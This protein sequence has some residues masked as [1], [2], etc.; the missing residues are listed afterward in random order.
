MKIRILGC[1]G[2]I[3]MPQMHTTALL[4]DDDVLI[5]AGTGVCRL[6]IEELA[7]VDHVFLTHSH[8][9]HIAALAFL[10]DTV[11]DI[12]QAP[13][14]VHATQATADILRNHIFNWEVWP[15]MANIPQVEQPF[16]QFSPIQV[17][18]PVALDGRKITPLPVNHTVPAVGYHLNSGFGSLVFSGDTGPCSEF[19]HK[20]NAIDNLRYL[21]LECAF[22]NSEKRLAEASLHM[23]PSMLGE[24]LAY[25]QHDV[26]L[27]ITHLK[28][29]Q[30]DITMRE[31]LAICD[32]WRPTMLQEDQVFEL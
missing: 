9:D 14:I 20:L 5:D 12:R 6:S 11:S 21:L 28:P 23:C 7:R 32:K 29:G 16:L 31:I 27:F 4:I 26:E 22:P 13:L 17:G 3:G 10:L 2:G 24:Q 15:D 8:L 25:L 1:S 30:G 18:H 19:W